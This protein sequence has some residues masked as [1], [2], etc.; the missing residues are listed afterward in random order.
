MHHCLSHICT[1][2]YGM[3]LVTLGHALRNRNVYYALMPNDKKWELSSAIG[4][5][6]SRTIDSAACVTLSL[7]D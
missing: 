2:E 3:T 1:T 5:A 4:S 6:M 7:C